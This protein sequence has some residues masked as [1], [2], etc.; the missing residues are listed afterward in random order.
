MFND[1]TG[2][3]KIELFAEVEIHRVS[4]HH[5]KAFSPQGFDL[6]MFVVQ[7]HQIRRCFSENAVNPILG[8]SA[9]RGHG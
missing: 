5:I 1:F 7:P 6:I 4:T 9:L 2:D 3:Y 8:L